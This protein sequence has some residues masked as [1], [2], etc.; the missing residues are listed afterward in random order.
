MTETGP[1]EA[2]F[3]RLFE[4]HLD[5]VPAYAWAAGPGVADEIVAETFLVAWRRLEDVADDALPWLIVGVPEDAGGYD[6]GSLAHFD[7]LI[8]AARRRPSTRTSRQL[9]LTDPER[10]AAAH[11]ARLRGFIPV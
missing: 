5:A 4:L 1:R 8:A 7:G 9:F 2:H 11:A 10:R 3:N 6:A